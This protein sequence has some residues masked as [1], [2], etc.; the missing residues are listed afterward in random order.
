MTQDL[1]ENWVLEANKA[2]PDQ[3]EQWRV[4]W[5]TWFWDDDAEVARVQ[6][7]YTGRNEEFPMKPRPFVVVLERLKLL[8]PDQAVWS[9]YRFRNLDTGMEVLAWLLKS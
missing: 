2:P 6:K 1:T 3:D 4:V 5:E 7:D 8:R 9:R